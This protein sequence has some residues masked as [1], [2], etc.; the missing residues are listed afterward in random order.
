MIA[1]TGRAQGALLHKQ[2]VARWPHDGNTRAAPTD[3][4][5]LFCYVVTAACA[6]ASLVFAGSLRSK[7][8]GAWNRGDW[9]HPDPTNHRVILN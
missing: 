1:K 3:N 8:V 2:V 7:A 4:S 5:V 6:V 9:R